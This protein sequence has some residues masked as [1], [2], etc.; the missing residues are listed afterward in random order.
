MQKHKQIVVFTACGIGF[1]TVLSIIL[2][3]FLK[4]DAQTYALFALVVLGGWTSLFGVYW[5]L[6]GVYKFYQAKIDAER[7]IEQIKASLPQVIEPVWVQIQGFVNWYES[8]SQDRKE[9]IK[10][11]LQ[12]AFDILEAKIK[13]ISQR[14]W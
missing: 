8:L 2:Y 3:P 1:L 6:Y 13:K 9:D 5:A 14:G 11:G 10:R 12:V 7:Q 4:Q